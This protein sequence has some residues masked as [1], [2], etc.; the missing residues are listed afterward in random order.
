MTYRDWD[1]AQSR[2]SYKRRYE[3]SQQALAQA[4]H[5]NR[6]HAECLKDAMEALDW[7]VGDAMQYREASEALARIEARLAELEPEEETE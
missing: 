2:A 5:E 6:V 1:K 4:M 3:A 7:Y